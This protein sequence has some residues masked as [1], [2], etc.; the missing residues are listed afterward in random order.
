MDSAIPD[1]TSEL[2]GKDGER[3]LDQLENVPIKKRRS[4]SRSSYSRV[5][6]ARA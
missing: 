4:L 2:E 5:A 3:D 1:A 6:A